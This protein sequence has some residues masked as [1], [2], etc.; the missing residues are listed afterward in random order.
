MLRVSEKP[1]IHNPE[2]QQINQAAAVNGIEGERGKQHSLQYLKMTAERKYD[3]LLGTD[4]VTVLQACMHNLT[5]PPRQR[6]LYKRM[7]A[8]I[9]VPGWLWASVLGKVR[10]APMRAVPRP[11]RRSR[12][13]P[14]SA[15][16][17]LRC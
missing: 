10:G 4:E 11:L 6:H 8:P 2:N 7:G 15:W 12:L 16:R 17:A 13:F 3:T 1:I 14:P 9:A 5:P